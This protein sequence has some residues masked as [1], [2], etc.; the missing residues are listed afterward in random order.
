MTPRGT[1]WSLAALVA[2]LAATG[3]LTALAGTQGGEWV[4]AAHGAGGFALAAVLAWKARRVWGRL[5][6]PRRW[7]GR[8]KAGVLAA[9]LVVAT[10][11]SGWAWASG[12]TP[13]G[14]GYNL[15]NLHVVLGAA[16]ALGVLGHAL[17]RARR[18]RRADV[19]DR[20]QFLTAAAV[21]AGSLLAWQLQRP[22]QRALGW[23]GAERR[24]TG[25]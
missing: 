17:I 2:L 25:S 1:D 13:R 9:L 22:A 23:R 19:T 10:L 7:R 21:G 18:P 20:R 16:L 24:F 8:A 14:L 15:L 6:H 11:G 5:S 4:F 12:Y 3:A